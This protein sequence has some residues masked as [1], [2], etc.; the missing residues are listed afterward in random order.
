MIGDLQRAGG[1]SPGRRRGREDG[2][3]QVVRLHALDRRR[4]LLAAPQAQHRERAVQVPPPAHREH[5]RGQDGL[6]D[7]AL[8]GRWRQEPGHAF[9]REAVLRPEREQDRV[10]A[11]RRLQLEVERDAEPLAQRQPERPVEPR[12]ER[13]VH[14]Q[15]HPAALVEEPFKDDG[16]Q[17][18]SC[19]SAAARR[20]QVGGDHRRRL[21]RSRKTPR[22]QRAASAGPAGSQPPGDRLAGGHRPPPT[23]PRC[24]PAPRPARTAPTAARPGRRPRAPRPARPG[25]CAR[26]WCRA[27][28]HRPPWTRSPSPR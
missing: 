13:R 12:P 6:P 27:G 17:S 20:S 23:A 15:L 16:V 4:V 26:R 24:G 5:R 25:G 3:H 8:H 2:H 21:R 10:V 1:R 28:T 18:G 22:S 11:R 9:E 14:D 19:P 7:H